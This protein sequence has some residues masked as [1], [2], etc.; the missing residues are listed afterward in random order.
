MRL[1]GIAVVAWLV[2]GVGS[3]SAASLGSGFFVSPDGHILTNYHVVHGC[4][5]TDVFDADAVRRTGRVVAVDEENDLALV[6]TRATAKAVAEFSGSGAKVG[7]SSWA[8]GF[9]LA[10]LLATSGN[11]TGGIIS[12]LA[13]LDNDSR[14]LQI[15]APVQPG[16]SG[17]PLL[18]QSGVV[19]GI[20]V[21]KLDA[22][23]V[24][25]VTHDVPQNVNFA[26]KAAIALDFLR[27]HSIAPRVSS[28][29]KPLE[30]TEVAERAKSISVR[31]VCAPGKQPE[32]RTAVK[33]GS[34]GAKSGSGDLKNDSGELAQAD[35]RSGDSPV[36]DVSIDDMIGRWCGEHSNYTFSRTDMV[37]T[38]VGNWKLTHAP[39]WV[40]D[41][42]E[43]DGS[44]IEVFWK[45]P[46]PGNS[47]AFELHDD[48]ET[49]I[50]LPQTEGDK[51]PRRVF[52]RC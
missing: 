12:A 1:R 44:Q 28:N 50:Q 2:A 16:N 45:P 52:H 8:F 32:E 40:I 35:S 47:T 34:P 33:N 26:I 27:S 30:Q 18:N 39:H 5:T 20:V 7:E 48:G 24:A 17:G 31:I 41:R 36:A 43:T 29:A 14:M 21:A 25:K 51:G 10:G 11:F 13:G 22:L 37:V 3:A 6:D 15:S 38:P 23:G 4:T 42:V 49:L 19:I 9:P 46:K